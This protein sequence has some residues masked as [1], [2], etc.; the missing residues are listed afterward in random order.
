MAGTVALIYGEE[1]LKYNFDPAHP[2]NPLRLKLTFELIQDYELLDNQDLTLVSPT[3]ASDDRLLSVHDK[4]YVEAVK[5]AS[6]GGTEDYCSYGLGRGD[7]PIFPGMHEAAAYTVGASVKA[8]DMVASGEVTRAFNPGG[9]LHHALK[10][11]ASGF[12]VYNDPAVAISHLLNR[13]KLRV[14]YLDVDA[15][16]GD[17]VQ[18][19]FYSS[20][21]VFTLSLHQSG[22]TLFPGTGSPDEVGDGAGAG[23]S[24]NVP[25]APGT[26][27]DAYLYA[28]REVVPVLSRIFCPDVIVC[29]FGCDGHHSDPLT[30]MNL[31]LSLYRQLAAD[32]DNLAHDVCGGKW[33]AL[34][35]GG[36]QPVRVV[37]RA[38]TALLG[39]MLSVTLPTE[40]PVSWVEKATEHDPSFS[41][42]LLLEEDGPLHDEQESD[43][44]RKQAV[45]AVAAVKQAVL[46]FHKA[47]T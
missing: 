19:L 8:A 23:Y 37:P 3:L 10:A 6:R 5:E 42:R 15:H 4:A 7:N 12:C 45:Q 32:I 28:F 1:F 16:H 29:Q 22:E 47:R 26:G 27:D 44:I 24:A 2:L 34:G 46:P 25:L 14:F 40:L 39:E 36:Y 11:R 33:I 18:W 43:M 21:E 20:P 35:G 13:Y 41:D 31:T 38:W 17:G 30:N 9:G